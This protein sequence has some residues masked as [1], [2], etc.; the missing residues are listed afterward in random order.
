MTIREE[1]ERKEFKRL[2]DAILASRQ[3]SFFSALK[4][5]ARTDHPKT[6]FS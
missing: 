5:R 2:S 1:A 4:D 3:E 6:I